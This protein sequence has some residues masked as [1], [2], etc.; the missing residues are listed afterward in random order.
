MVDHISIKT[1]IILHSKYGDKQY[2]VHNGHTH[3]KKP[4]L[5]IDETHLA[6]SGKATSRVC[7]VYM[8]ETSTPPHH[9]H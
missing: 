8:N 9:V 3:K 1:F 2:F 7:I 5:K 6:K 4:E